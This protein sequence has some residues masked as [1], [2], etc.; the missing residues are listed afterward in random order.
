MVG[1]QKRQKSLK[2]SVSELIGNLGR[3]K[4]QREIGRMIPI[5]KG[6]NFTLLKFFHF[7]CFSSRKIHGKNMWVSNNLFSQ[8]LHMHHHLP[9]FWFGDAL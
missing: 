8:I 1:H 4:S 3:I 5:L 2:I 9:Q 7:A 6:N